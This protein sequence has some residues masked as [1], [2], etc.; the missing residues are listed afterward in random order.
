MKIIEN[1]KKIDCNII[2]DYPIGIMS[3]NDIPEMFL[4][5]SLFKKKRKAGFKS[6]RNFRFYVLI[7]KKDDEMNK[8]IFFIKFKHQSIS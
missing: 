4:I 2:L 5:I 1:H 7:L 3:L 6:T 8:R